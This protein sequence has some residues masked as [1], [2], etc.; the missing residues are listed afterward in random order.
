MASGGGIIEFDKSGKTSSGSY[1]LGKIEYSYTQ[2]TANNTSTVTFDVYVK[3]DNDSTKLTVTTNGTF[4]Y[5]LTVNGETITGSN[6]LEILTSY[7]KIGSFTRTINHEN[8]G[9]KN[10]SIVGDVWLSNN[11]SS[12]Y[13]NKKSHINDS[14][15]LKTIPRASSITSAANVTLGN[16]CNIKWTPMAS[17]FAYKVELSCGGITPHISDYITPGSTSEC[18]YST[19]MS[20]S[21]WASTIPASYSGICKATLYTYMNSSSTSPIGSSSASFTI[22][23]PSHHKVSIESILVGLENGWKGCFVQGK[24]QCTL[25]A[26]FA[27]GIGSSIQSCSISGTGL[28]IKGAGESISGTSSVLT[29]AGVFEYTVEVADGRSTASDK[30]GIRVWP[31]AAPV[32]STFNAERTS[33]SGQVKITYK[34]SCSSIDGENELIELKIYKK[35]SSEDKWEEDATETFALGGK[36]SGE[37]ILSKFIPANNSD[38]GFESTKSYD[39]K[40]IVTDD[41]GTHYG[42][43]SAAEYASVQSEFR[44]I[45]ISAEKTGLSIGKMYDYVPEGEDDPSGIFDCSLPAH[46]LNTIEFGDNAVGTL[47]TDYSEDGNGDTRNIVYIQTGQEVSKDDGTTTGAVMGLAIHNKSVYVENAANSSIVNLGSNGRKWNQLYAANGTISTSD[48]SVKTDITSMSDAQEQLFNKLQPVTFKFTNGSSGRIHYG[49]VSQDVEESL[50]ELN[51]TGQDFAGFC[52]DLRVDD[53]GNA[54]LD[55]NNKKTY[56]YSLRYS[57]FIA[58][59]T[60]MIQKLQ[61]ENKELKAELQALKE[62]IININA[63]SNSAE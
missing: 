60:Y 55:E 42:V 57:E 39:F 14:I 25:S 37:I 34:A 1:V 4:K 6:S 5:S 30:V 3:K 18:T 22:T 45:N 10:L 9:S 44:I 43:T 15:A 29:K 47:K 56:D 59:N 58:L 23:I 12:A 33:I 51:L 49:F 13:Y 7:K 27:A 35:L 8:N 52:K 41:C 53:S 20:L 32:L 28:S 61:T 50:A 17:S 21:T 31:Y 38:P 11:S 24:S 40:A 62:M 19:A 54:I 46:F 36:S 16:K 2:S 26:D 63:S 48:R